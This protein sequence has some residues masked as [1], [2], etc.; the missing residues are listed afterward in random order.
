MGVAELVFAAIAAVAAIVAVLPLLGFDIRIIGRPKM[1]VEGLPHVRSKQAWIALGIATI[2]LVVSGMAFYYFF[3]PRVV[4]KI[5]EKPVDRIVEKIVQKDCP[6]TEPVN[7]SKHLSIPNQDPKTAPPLSQECALGANC[8][9]S[10]GQS[11]GITAGQINVGAQDWEALLDGSKQ[12]ALIAALKKSK[13]KFQLEW[14]MQDVGAMKMAGFIN[15]AF[16]QAQWMASQP[17]GYAGSMCYPSQENDC[18]GLYITVKDRN[19]QPAK[20]AITAISAFFPKVHV[21]ESDK[22]PD[23]KIHVLIAKASW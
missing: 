10:T 13:G 7:K 8:A 20:T 15:Y 14:L 16:L 3:R 22:E 1:P 11:G 9:Q 6:K 17:P 4:E 19:G 23:D 18:L 12:N 21:I 2:S 5:V